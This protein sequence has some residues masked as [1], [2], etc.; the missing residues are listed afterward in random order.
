VLGALLPFRGSLFLAHSLCSLFLEVVLMLRPAVRTL[1]FLV[2]LALSL[3]GISRA[4]QVDPKSYGGMKWRLIGPFRGG[5]ALTVTGVPSQ[6]HTYYF[7]AVSGGVW[8]TTDG[9]IT[10]DAISDKQT[11]SSIGAIA[12][13]DSDPNILYAGSGEACIRGNISYG[14]GVYKSTDAGKTWANVGLKDSQHIGKV[15]VHPANPDIVF[16][17]A[18]GH[19]YGAN[20]ERGIFRTRDGGKNWEKVLYVNDR[21]GGIDIVFDPHNPHVLFAA[22]WEGYRTPWMLNSGGENSG[23]YRSGDEGATWKR[24]EGNGMPEGPLGRIGVGVSG[25]DSNVVYA[26]IEAK[27]GGLYRS[28]DGGT[29]WTLIN[30]DHRFRQRA[31]YFTH[32]WADPKNANTV[33]IANT[34]LFRSIDGGKSFER[35]NAPHGDHHGLW[36]DP[37]DTNRMINGNDGGAT[38]SVDGGK[39]WSTQNNQPTAQFYHVVAD[40]D[41][42][43]RVYGSQQDNSNVA[44]RTRSDHG[45]IDRGDWEAVGGGESG[46]IAPD[47]RDS[48]IVYADDEGP[49]LTRFD[50]TTGQAQSIQQHPEDL[51]G[52]P[53]SSQKYRYT[54]TMPLI[55]SSHNPEVIYH[56]SQYVLRSADAGHTWTEISPDLTRNDKSKQGDSGGPITK[57]QYTVEYYDVVFALAESPK[58]DGVLWAGTDDGLIHVTRDAGKTWSKV[59]PKDLPEWGMVSLIAASPFDAA[60]AY[61]AVD[62]HKLDNFKPY[63]FKTSDFGKSWTKI[64]GGLPENDYVHAVREDP[65]RKGLLYAGTETGVWVSFDDGGHWQA[66]QLNLP[67]T[68][69]HDLLVHGNDLTVATHGRSF[70]VLDDLAPLRQMSAA[71]ASENAHLFAPS[72][73]TRTRIGHVEPRRYPIGENPPHGAILYYWLKEA[74]KEAAKLEVLDAQGKVIRAFT[75]EQKKTAEA[76]DEGERDEPAENIPAAAGLNRFAWDLRYEVPAKIPAAIYDGGNNP[77]GPLALPGKYSVR[78]TVAGKS[79]T[80]PLEI[81]MDPRVKTSAADLQKQFDLLLKLRDR[82]EELNR[83]VLGI[84]DLRGQLQ[85]I[86]KRFAASESAKSVLASAADLRKKLTAIEEEL[87]QVNATASED[88][89]NYPTRLNSKFSYLNGV[90]DSADTAPTAAEEGVFADLNQQLEKQLAQWREVLA[91]D[92]PALNDAMQKNNVPLIGVAPE[93]KH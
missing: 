38:I 61:V 43:Y 37:H 53:A 63:I 49:F 88:E 2:M 17:A 44:I 31:W 87:I 4:Q 3:A 46:Y 62:A 81:A 90:T 82:Q 41:F 52:H 73:A 77:A 9:G 51:S 65:A 93:A 36:V 18:L 84:R 72:A 80:Q 34:G 57:D 64:V 35:L 68:P 5:R 47:P 30:P 26:L 12:V 92:L 20:T 40:N 39:N 23:L 78:L 76:P 45:F 74:P 10:W 91:K 54:W 89:A 58:Q 22:M 71:I 14:D 79:S 25:G 59:T 15:I 83:A 16:V 29:K 8:K 1:S 11:I 33:Y 60:T 32:V 69:I 48:N 85:A 21:T 67:N 42:L 70:W 19:A 28:D 86:E 50:R 13:A 6:P 7:G 27:K 66:L 56:T 75:S 24:I 55:V